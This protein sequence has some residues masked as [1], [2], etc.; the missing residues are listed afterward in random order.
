MRTCTRGCLGSCVDNS[1][2]IQRSKSFSEI[3]NGGLRH[4]IVEQGPERTRMGVAVPLLEAC[5]NRKDIDF[6]TFAAIG[7]HGSRYGCEA[8]Q[9]LAARRTVMPPIKLQP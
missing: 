9:H 6:S 7:E 8:R 5:K 3:D 4:L 2:A 1:A